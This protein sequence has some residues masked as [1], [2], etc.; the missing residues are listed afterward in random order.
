MRIHK[1]ARLAALPLAATLASLAP[2]S[3]AAAE[4]GEVVIVLSEEP[5]MIDPCEAS[6]SNVGRIVKQNVTE[7]LTEIDPDDGSITPR[8]ATEWEQV[9][10]TT[11]RFK[12]KEGVKFHDG[13]DFTAAAAKTAIERTLDERIDCEIRIKFFGGMAVTPEVVDEHTL[14]IKTAEPAPILPTMM[15]TMTIV[16][17]NT[18]MGERTRDPIGTGPY[19]FTS[20]T[21][22]TSVVLERFDEYWGDQPEV[23]KVTYVFRGESAVRAAMVATGEADI[24]PNVAVQDATDPDMD[25]SYFN[26]ETSSYRID[27]NKPPLDDVRVR[28][29]LNLAIDRDAMIGS[30]FSEDVVK[31]TQMVV[32]SINGHNPDLEPWPYEPE[33]AKELLAE[34]EAD[35]VPVGDEITIVGRLEIYPNATEHAEATMAML[36]EAGFNV[37]L[38]MLEVAEWVDTYTKPYA[39][40]RPPQL[41][42]TQHDN[43]NGDAVF[44]VFFKYHSDGAQSIL[45]DPELDA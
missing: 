8:L 33:Q 44:T 13:E 24:A 28:K 26:S 30:I 32:P 6:R 20:W 10:D 7:T 16:S 38:Q 41:V 18:V 31:A 3:V 34:A 11:W 17:P 19:R 14:D 45:S 42:Q 2:A 4:E 35:G 5:D 22:G 9:D 12:L 29:A 39:E 40:D 15:G 36:Q 21:P 27:V 25:F 37:K 1:L 43:N 23:E